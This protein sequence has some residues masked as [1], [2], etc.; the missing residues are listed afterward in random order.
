M[1]L[2]PSIAPIGYLPAQECIPACHAVLCCSGGSLQAHCGAL[3]ARGLPTSQLIPLPAQPN[4]NPTRSSCPVCGLPGRCR[5]CP[6][7]RQ[8][9]WQLGAP[10][11]GWGRGPHACRPAASNCAG[12]H[13]D[14]S[15][16]TQDAAW[17]TACG[18]LAVRS[19]TLACAH[20]W[21]PSAVPCSGISP[22]QMTAPAAAAQQRA[23]QACW[24]RAPA[25]WHVAWVRGPRKLADRAGSE[26]PQRQ[27]R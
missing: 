9:C 7:C 21:S 25:S 15:H 6:W 12:W 4:S 3:P 2:A 17:C 18:R 26:L 22:A 1:V 5:S 8:P 24:L 11:Q 20:Y 23:W 13:S 10:A 16:S 27:H 14:G 19:A